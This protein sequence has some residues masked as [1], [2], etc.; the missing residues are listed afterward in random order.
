MRRTIL[1]YG[2]LMA[3]LIFLLKMLEYRYWIYDLRMEFYIGAVALLFTALGVWAGLRLNARR[4]LVAAATPAVR[5]DEQIRAWGITTREAEVL[6]L[7]AAGLSNQEIA[8]KLFISVPTVKTH[9]ANLFV[10]LDVRRRTQA[11]QKARQEGL[12]Q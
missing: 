2:L 9:T 12:I 5:I 7:M 6:A 3:V 4:K 10:K 8:G 1:L 11:V